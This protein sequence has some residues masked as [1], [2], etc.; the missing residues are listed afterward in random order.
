[1]ADPDSVTEL[2]RLPLAEEVAR[3]LRRRRRRLVRVAVRTEE[4]PQTL[5]ASR[6]RRVAEVERV[7]V[8]RE[9]PSPPPIRQ[10]GDTVVVPVLEERLVLVRRLV[11]TEEIRFRLRTEE[12]PVALPATLRR[13][14][15]TVE[16]LAETIED[17]ADHIAADHI[18]GENFM[19]RTLTALLSL[20]H[21]SRRQLCSV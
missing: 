19:Q 1:M 3:I 13:Q 8:G 14:S 11:L 18:A 5:Q 7:P 2:G 10:E 9:V 21:K 15:V 12:E 6:R 17:I 16:R 20:D 4:Q